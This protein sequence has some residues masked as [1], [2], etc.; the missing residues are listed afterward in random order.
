MMSP[1]A[2]DLMRQKRRMMSAA[3]N[4]SWTPEMHR[5]LAASIADLTELIF[6]GT[7]R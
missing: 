4:P 3:T 6:E 7:P 2:Q 5:I 1:Q